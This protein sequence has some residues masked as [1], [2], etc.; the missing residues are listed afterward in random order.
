MDK[1]TRLI[2][3][4]DHH[5]RIGGKAIRMVNPPV[6]AG[7]T[8]LFENYRDFALA[9]TGEYPGVSYGTDRLSA[10]RCLEEALAELEGGQLCRVFQSGISAITHTLQA[11]LS[12]GDHLLI[13]ENVYGPTAR[14]CRE[15]LPRFNIETDFVPAAIGADIETFIRPR[16]RLIFLESPGSNTF[17]IQDVPAIT[18]IARKRDLITVIDN[19][20]A[21]PLYF[22]PLTLGVDLSIQSLTKYISGHS[23]LLLGAVSV[24]ERCAHLLTDYYR[25]LELFVSPQDAYLAL[26]SLKTLEV[27]LQRHEE[28]ALEIAHWLE[29]RADIDQVLHPALPKHPQHALWQRDFRGSSGLFAFTFRQ[30][31]PEEKIATFIDTLELF[32]LGY[33]WGG[34]KSLVTVGRYE[35]RQGGRPGQLVVRLSIGLEKPADLIS[36]LRRGLAVLG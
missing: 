9:G 36:D 11:C 14:F 22:Q 21:T 8:V 29:R 13:C 34:F 23:D 18:A 20:W 1:I 4:T 2:S 16:T 33:S 26:R 17:E 27:R 24:N 7:S 32:G 6:S 35:R 15:V 5:D 10:Q 30:D 19:T 3:S 31:Y 28:S 12:S 25:T